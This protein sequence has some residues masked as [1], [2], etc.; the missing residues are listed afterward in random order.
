[1]VRTVPAVAYS[2]PLFLT[3]DCLPVAKPSYIGE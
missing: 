2:Q 3:L 1:M